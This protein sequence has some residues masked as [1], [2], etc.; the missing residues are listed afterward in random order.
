MA[1]GKKHGGIGQYVAVA[2]I[3]GVITFVEF[4]IVEWPPTFMSSSWVLF[5]LVALSLVKFWMVIWFFMHL[6]DD[7]KLYT[8][9]FSSGMVIAMGTF[10]AL[11][12]LFLLP[13]AVAPNVSAASTTAVHGDDGHGDDGHGAAA[14]PADVAANIASDGASRSLAERAASPRPADRSL[15]VAPPAAPTDGFGVRVDARAADADPEALLAQAETSVG[16]DRELGAQVY[17]ANCAACHQASGAGIPSVFP[18]L[19]GHAADLYRAEGGRTYLIDVLLYGL[20]GQITVDG[21]NYAGAM[22]GWRQLGDEQIAA[23]VNHIVVGFEGV[24]E[25]DG[26]EPIQPAEVA[27]Q[28]GETLTPAQVLER[29][30]ALGEIPPADADGAPG[31]D[32]AAD[33]PSDETPG[34]DAPAA[35]AP[36]AEAPADPSFD[37]EAAAQAFASNCAACHQATGAGIPGAFPPLAGHAADVYSVEGGRSYLIDVLLYGLQGPIVVNGTSYNG[38]MPA[39][40]QLSDEQVA[41][42]VNHAVAGFPG[43]EAPADFDAVQASEVAAQRGRGLSGA[44]V[45]EQRAALGL[46]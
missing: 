17:A 19:A 11:A 13:R 15:V 8:G 25:P 29:R 46:E 23:V 35:E 43:A 39:F 44:Q 32:A 28:R 2:L 12:F 31:A 5:W 18:P 34:A 26:F 37:R 36:A 9:F 24:V 45:A 27:A 20:Q 41:L 30:S 4:A 40:S 6:K 42:I 38:L 10:V 16:F 3:L 1:H 22:P 7:D 33:A 14:L 21:T